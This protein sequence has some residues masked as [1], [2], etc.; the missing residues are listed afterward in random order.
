MFKNKVLMITGG[1]GSFGN[2]VLSRFLD[3]ELRE[4]RIFSRDEKKQEEMRQTYNNS[5]LKFFIG[6]VRDYASI[7]QALKGVDYIFH[8]AA[9]KQ[10][11]SCEF[12]PL[13]A[14]K[15]NT[16]GAENVMTAA[17]A[18]KV[19]KVVLLSTDKAVYPINA[20]GMSKALMEKIMVAKSRLQE[21]GDTVFCAT[22]YG[23]VMA[24]RG[25]VIPLFIS[26]IKNDEPITIT[27]PTMTRFLMS[28]DESVD[29]VMM[30]F[31]NCNQ[32]DIFVQKASACTIETLASALKE[33]FQSNI[34][35]DTIG[36]RHGE[37]LYESLI[38]REEMVRAEDMGPWY[39]IPS[40]S[41]DLNYDKYFSDGEKKIST[42][43]D[44]TSHNTERLDEKQTIAL[45]R[46][47]DY[48][49]NILQAEET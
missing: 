27:D 44:Y 11:P 10:V 17:I 12:Y 23:N 38:S 48:I 29:L 47:L 7:N 31:K 21:E 35:I 3:T 33:I 36:T 18:N 19:K 1:T 37:K 34:S 28:L 4:I 20:M 8:A 22:R 26:Q 42:S 14:I 39:R 6:D 16:L 9:L 25:S 24:S 32:G 49:Q 43:E 30:A 15:T 5:K 46:N 45:L 13:E 2:K 40:D 41:R